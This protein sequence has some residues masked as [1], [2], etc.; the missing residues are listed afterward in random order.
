M[1]VDVGKQDMTCCKWKAQVLHD[2]IY[3]SQVCIAYSMSTV[4]PGIVISD[5]YKHI[6][7]ELY[8]LHH[9]LLLAHY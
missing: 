6:Q 4:H 9:S 2:T 3:S 5:L 1:R 7:V 8:S